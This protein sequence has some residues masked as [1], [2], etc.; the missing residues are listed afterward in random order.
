MR[1]AF[2][3]RIV[4]RDWVAWVAAITIV[5]QSFGWFAHGL[6]DAAADGDMAASAHTTV[7][8]ASH[9]GF[10]SPPHGHHVKNGTDPSE[11]PDPFCCDLLCCCTSACSTQCGANSQPTAGLGLLPPTTSL[12]GHISEYISGPRTDTAARSFLARAPPLTV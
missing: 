5:V 1:P 6:P 11:Q 7:H 4:K 10:R 2:H 9:E 3:N 12:I 8:M